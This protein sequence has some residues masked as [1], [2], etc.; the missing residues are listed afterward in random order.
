MVTQAQ[1]MLKTELRSK[2]SEDYYQT[3]RDYVLHMF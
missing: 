1:E 2:Q 3:T